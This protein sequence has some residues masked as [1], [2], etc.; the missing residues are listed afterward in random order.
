MAGR[1][2]RCRGES[3]GQLF[4]LHLNGELL[5]STPL[6]ILMSEEVVPE[7]SSYSNLRHIGDI[8]SNCSEFKQEASFVEACR[9]WHME[10]TQWNKFYFTK[11]KWVTSP[12]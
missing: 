10:A 2:N 4:W 1:G 11:N 6:D 5:E 8:A 3:R 12:N 7:G 9:W